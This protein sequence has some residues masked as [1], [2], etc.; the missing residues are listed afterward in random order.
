MSPHR[1]DR[2][3]PSVLA[4]D[5]RV[6]PAAP[7]APVIVEPLAN[8]QVVSGFDV[9][10]E[11]NPNRYSDPDGDPHRSTTW[12]VRE[13]VGGPVVWQ[14]VAVTDPLS[15]VHIHQGDGRFVGPLSAATSFPPD[16]GY[17]LEVT[18]TDAR[19]EASATARRA[20]VTAPAAA[21]VPGAGT[22]IV[23]EGYALEPAAT[24]GAFRLPVNIAFV[25]NPGPGAN[26][27]LYYVAELY[28][29]VKVVTRG[30]AVSTYATGLLDYNPS[31]P[32]AG[33]GEQGLAGLAVDPATGDLYVGMLWNA[34]APDSARGGAGRHYAKVERLRSGDGG[35]TVAVREHVWDSRPETQGASHQISNLSFGP[36]GRLYVHMGDGFDT[37]SAR[38]AN[39]YRGKVLRM[40]ADGS[41]AADNP[42]YNAGDGISPRDYVYTFGHRNAFGGAWR[43]ADGKHYVV[44]NGNHIDRLVDLEPGRDYGWSGGD[45]A[46]R[47]HSLHVWDP[48][49]APV[50]IAFVQRRTFGG[51]LFPASARDAAFVSLSGPTYAAGPQAHGKRI[52][53]FTGLDARS[54]G[55]LTT[56]PVTLVS[57]NGTGR[58]TVAG[59]AA[60]PDGLYFS[61]LYRDDGAGGP[62]AEG[63]SVYRLRYVDFPPRNVAAGAADERVTLTWQANALAAGYNVYRSAGSGARGLIARNVTG[64]TFTDPTVSGGTQYRYFVRGVNAGGESSDSN[65]VRVTPPGP[66]AQPPAV[67]T[68][69]AA[70]PNPATGTTATLAALGADDRPEEL[71]TYTW[72]VQ[73][74]PPGPVGF[75][76]NGTNA[77]KTVTATFTKAGNY[78]LAVTVR[79]AGGRAAVAAVS[80]AVEQAVSGVAVSPGRTAVPDGGSQVF[81][82]TALDQFGDPLARQPSFNW[83]VADGGPGTIDAAGMFAAP[84]GATGSATVV[85][86]TSGVAGS[87]TVAVAPAVDSAG[88]GLVGAYYAK[89]N[90]TGASVLRA[91]ERVNFR[92]GRGSPHWRIPADRFSARWT[93]A[94]E[95]RFTETYTFS[96]VSD[97]GVRL[98]VD[99]RL[100][101]D[102]WDGHTAR[103]H[104][105]TIEL[106][107]GFEYDIRVD[108]YDRT[109]D[110]VVR[111]RWESASQRRELVPRS[112]L[113]SNDPLRINFQPAGA[114]VP[115]GYSADAGAAFADRGGGLAYGWDGDYA[116]RARDRDSPLAPGQQFDTLIRLQQPGRA[117]AVWEVAVPN[118]AYRVRVVCGDA[119]STDGVYKTDVE[120]VA[121]V[122]G[123]PSSGRRWVDGWADVVVADGR[124][125]VTSA[126]GAENNRIN[127][128]EI[129]SLGYDF[130]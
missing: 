45:G 100:V 56:A 79:D 99:G 67:A 65:E 120:G 5:D 71:L 85:A 122:R 6:L 90:F 28:G 98:W 36:D 72:A 7:A 69:P 121:A 78:T 16:R 108:Y 18:Y 104:R 126:D 25:P 11:V 93:G 22:W 80:V 12:R 115:A 103:E 76:A 23:R 43:A 97:E 68:P 21:P 24:E 81:A 82:A 70:D 128:I 64:T 74:T 73:G 60:G 35:R 4:L 124:L 89:T 125:T 29:S 40:N 109:G 84:A 41:A 26:A 58:A 118:G 110:A 30:G 94:I 55:K 77:A 112:Q 123:R 111:L 53:Q 3:R 62:T 92:F 33:S 87:A 52:E 119:N 47:D 116:T 14:A 63:A 34:G 130:G 59:L 44:E 15:R 95:P 75:S 19:G 83:A 113:Y 49:T 37:A 66:P 2:F 8:G 32:F 57:Y 46:L 114:R 9:H 39:R 86:T 38:D 129:V 48:S 101:I 61:T 96:T 27:P 10:M 42:F 91:G 88:T 31:G 107:A 127:F 50:N 1:R 117:D 106:V 20:F 102:R 54:G 51:S 17:V 105:G 13:S